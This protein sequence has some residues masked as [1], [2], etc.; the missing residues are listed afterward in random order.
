MSKTQIRIRV[1]AIV[2][3][4]G[5]ILWRSFGLALM[6]L[7]IGIAAGGVLTAATGDMGALFIGALGG[8]LGAV[9][10]AWAEIGEEIATTAKVTKGGINRGFRAAVK[11]IE[12]Q[13]A[14]AEAKKK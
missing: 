14:E 2:T 10:K 7:P 6:Y 3:V 12:Q 4:I 9:L 5:E 1:K 8:W 11:I 13:E